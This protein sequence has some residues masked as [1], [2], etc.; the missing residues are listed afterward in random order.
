MQQNRVDEGRKLSTGVVP[1]GQRDVSAAISGFLGPPETKGSRIEGTASAD[2]LSGLSTGLMSSGSP[3]L[4][5]EQPATKDPAT[6]LRQ[7]ESSLPGRKT[8]RGR[9][10]NPDQPAASKPGQRRPA[11]QSKKS[12]GDKAAEQREASK[13][14]EARCNEKTRN[15]SRYESGGE[16]PVQRPQ[17][18]MRHNHVAKAAAARS[19][20]IAK[21]EAS[22]PA[23]LAVHENL[24]LKSML[25]ASNGA[26][27]RSLMVNSS[28][29]S[30]PEDARVRLFKRLA[31][32]HIDSPGLADREVSVLS[33]MGKALNVSLLNNSEK[34]KAF[35]LS[36]ALNSGD[37][38]NLVRITEKGILHMKDSN[39]RSL[40]DNLAR[41]AQIGLVDDLDGQKVESEKLVGRLLKDLQISRR[42]PL[43]KHNSGLSLAG[44]SPAEYSRVR[45]ELALSGRSKLPGGGEVTN[46]VH[47]GKS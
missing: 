40:L 21:L 29:S 3:D 11:E 1:V 38:P 5:T 32:T 39:N 46:K 19:A 23:A 35:Q 28:F 8:G 47:P 13:G 22:L 41:L 16:E 31:A 25:K 27:L 43:G 45:V 20:R 2:L 9:E 30:L 24:A 7:V 4:L 37:V 6:G 33:R 34:Q 42:A 17:R 15:A 44:T 36:L 26:E 18:A 10:S 14:K 12:E